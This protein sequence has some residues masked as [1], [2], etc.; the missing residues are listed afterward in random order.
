ML[1]RWILASFHLVA[2]AIGAGGIWARTVALRSERLD[3]AELGRV[4]RA[5]TFWGVAAALWLI[6]GLL[7]AFAGFEKGA[8]Y[9]LGN[10]LFLTKMALFLLLVALEIKPMLTL[11]R[12]RRAVT[13]GEAIDTAPARGMARVSMIQSHILVVMILLAAAM[14]RGIGG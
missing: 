6:T 7:R 3:Q 4:F 9:Y 14:A 1:V 2:L 13:R 8:A 12:W 10:Y 11:M 5:D